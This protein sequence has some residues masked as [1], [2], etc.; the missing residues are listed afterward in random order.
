MRNNAL[1]AMAKAQIKDSFG[2]TPLK[3]MDAKDIEDIIIPYR[4]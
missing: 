1:A 2:S 3:N 4:S